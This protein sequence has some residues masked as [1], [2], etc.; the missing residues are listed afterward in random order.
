VDD[1]R[2]ADP[3]GQLLE[4]FVRY[5][6]D[7]VAVPEFTP[8]G[9]RRRHRQVQWRG[10]VFA[11]AFATMAV[12]AAVALGIAYG[13]RSAR[14]G[15]G[16]TAVGKPPP[17]STS[18]IAAGTQEITYQPFTATGIDPALVVT[19]HVVGTCI[20]YSRGTGM[21]TYLRCFGDDHGIYDPCFAGPQDTRA[22]LVC[23]TSP[24]SDDVVEFTVTSVTSDE[25]PT[26]S[27]IPWALQLSS[28]QVCLL[29][30]AAWSG[31]GPYSCQPAGAPPIVSDCHTP[32]ASQPSWIAE[33]QAQE[34]AASPFTSETVIK[35]W[36]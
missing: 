36:F 5:V 24:T 20:R 35:V 16:P 28:G 21:H 4:E 6:S 11:I 22:P 18:S 14:I 1:R 19:Q 34:T 23:P 29:V 12:A 10:R 15:P 13:P 25:P 9:A 8:A 30:S 26:P 27:T 7:Q 33:C 32:Q 2:S 31:L 3:T 17:A